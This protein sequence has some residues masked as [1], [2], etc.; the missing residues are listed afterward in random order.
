MKECHIFNQRYLDLSKREERSRRG[1]KRI[2]YLESIFKNRRKLGWAIKILCS[3][4]L[5]PASFR[6][7]LPL[8]SK[9][10]LSRLNTVG[11][12]RSA[13]SMR[14]QEPASIAFVSVPSI[15]S[16]LQYAWYR[17]RTGLLVNWSYAMQL[18]EFCIVCV[19]FGLKKE[20][21]SCTQVR[22][23]SFISCK[24]DHYVETRSLAQATELFD[25]TKYL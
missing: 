13:F 2:Q 22:S 16:N 8:G 10:G 23:K 3:P 24:S 1:S 7:K 15:H 11:L 5:L 17:L 9:R 19:R 14:T 25:Q 20:G 18:P 6:S 21:L 12:Q 4:F